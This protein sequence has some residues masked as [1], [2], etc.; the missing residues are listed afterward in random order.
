MS[1]IDDDVAR[2]NLGSKRVLADP[3]NRPLFRALEKFAN[4]LDCYGYNVEIHSPASLDRLALTANE[5]KEEI[6]HYY[7]N[8][9]RIIQPLAGEPAVARSGA[10]KEIGYAKKALKHHSLYID[11]DFW[12]TVEDDHVIE[13]YSLEMTQLYRSF[14][15]F[16]YC[17]YSLLDMSLNEWYVLWQRPKK[18]IEAMQRDVNEVLSKALPVFKARIP[19]HV[20]LE[21]MNTGNTANFVPRAAVIEFQN[22]GALKSHPLEKPAAFICTAVGEIIARGDEAL[23]IGF[24]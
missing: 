23:N 18:I 4:T 19:C 3:S 14:N 1:S 17:G 21:T 15:F 2:Q 8:W 12:E 13:I 20:L 16:K 10:S 6:R 24:I 5:K 11:D 9:N 22:L 7:E